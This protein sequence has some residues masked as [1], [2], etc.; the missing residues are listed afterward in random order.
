M[1]LQKPSI[2]IGDHD[3]RMGLSRHRM[4]IFA[5]HLWCHVLT[6]LL[7]NHIDVSYFNE[8]GSCDP[9]DGTKLHDRTSIIWP[10]R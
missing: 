10:C 2:M 5:E 4:D 1:L 3:W 9:V 8:H 7:T 6:L